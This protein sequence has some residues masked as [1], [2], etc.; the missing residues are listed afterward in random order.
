M[1]DL[2]RYIILLIY[3]PEFVRFSV[4]ILRGSTKNTVLFSFTTVSTLVSTFHYCY[5]KHYQLCFP[6]CIKCIVS[7]EPLL[8]TQGECPYV[9]DSNTL[10]GTDGGQ[11]QVGRPVHNVKH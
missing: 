11:R 3:L 4:I 10:H 8:G 7:C 1:S 2:A 9:P 5:D 6:S